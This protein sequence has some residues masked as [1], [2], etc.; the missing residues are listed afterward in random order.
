MDAR[1]K[2]HAPTALEQGKEL[3]RRESLA[4]NQKPVI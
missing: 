1:C 4:G 2:R 3:A